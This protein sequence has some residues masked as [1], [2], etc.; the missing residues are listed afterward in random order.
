MQNV[1]II[2]IGSYLPKRV[3]SNKELAKIIAENRNRLIAEG[4]DFTLEEYKLT[5][6]SDEWIFDHIGIIER[7]I[8]ADDE[9]TSDLAV[10]AAEDTLDVCGLRKSAIG[11]VLLATVSPDHLHSPPT[12]SLIQYKLGLSKNIFAADVSLACSSFIIALQ[13]GDAL[14][15]SGR[16]RYGLVIGADVM[17]RTVNWCDRSF[18]S[19]L[20][21]AGACLA[22]GAGSKDSFISSNP[23]TAGIDGSL[24]DI[25]KTEAGGSRQP[26]DENIIAAIA[27]K[28][29]VRPDKL[30]MDGNKVYKMMVPMVPQIILDA[31]NKAQLQVADLDM[32]F[33]HQANGRMTE[34]ITERLKRIDGFR[35]NIFNNIETVANTTSA[36]IPISLCQ[37]WHQGV[38]KPD[39]KIILV[40]F[41]GG[42]S[43]ATALIRW[44]FLSCC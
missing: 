37:A 11:F 36:S 30:W 42:I 34:G 14:I 2:G 19:I 44:P 6:T 15:R 31:L 35:A 29:H 9:A 12:S 4:V 27:K 39:M 20:G 10:R 3:V 13:M 40:V 18:T 5:D 8:A 26:L 43:W 33:L 7:R 1:E 24:G 28:P 22:L 38:L 32:I 17:T 21:D 16:Y 41:G 25:I 23:F